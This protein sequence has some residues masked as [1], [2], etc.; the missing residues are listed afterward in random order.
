MDDNDIKFM[1]GDVIQQFSEDW[2]PGNGIDM[3]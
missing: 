1:T 2:T 3:G